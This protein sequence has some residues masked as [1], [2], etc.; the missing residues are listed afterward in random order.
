MQG[1]LLS[2]TAAL[3]L[4]S[5][6]LKSLHSEFKETMPELTNL[7]TKL[8]TINIEKRRNIKKTADS[9]LPII[10]TIICK[11]LSTHS[12]RLSAAKYVISMVLKT[13]GAKDT[14]I[15][16]LSFVGDAMSH[17]SVYSKLNEMADSI[18]TLMADWDEPVVDSSIIFDNVNPYITVRQETQSKHGRLHSLTQAIAVRDR[19]PTNQISSAPKWAVAD[20]IPEQLIPALADVEV[21][22][23][24]FVTMVRNIWASIIPALSWMKD[25]VPTHKYSQYAS[26]T[27]QVVCI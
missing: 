19:V 5:F 21:L 9:I 11:I 6:N 24:R 25:D 7:I 1:S 2:M 18:D 10:V 16:R 14:C 12:Q 3:D 26:K 23:L 17:T 22:Q 15:D 8:C 4:P 27:S 20:V 13:G